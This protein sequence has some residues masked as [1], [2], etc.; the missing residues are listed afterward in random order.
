MSSKFFRPTFFTIDPMMQKHAK[1]KKGQQ[2]F[3]SIKGKEE[4]S[5][6][7]LIIKKKRGQFL[8]VK[9]VK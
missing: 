2:Q 1:P 3:I 4:Q 9:K 5:E 6:K 8:N 7:F